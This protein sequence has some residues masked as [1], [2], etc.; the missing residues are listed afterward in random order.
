MFKRIW[1]ASLKEVL[2]LSY[3]TLAFAG[4]AFGSYYFIKNVTFQKPENC[5]VCHYMT[6]SYNKWA[7]STHSK[8]PCL[9]C[10]NYTPLDSV[11]SQVKFLA[12]TY[13]YNRRPLTN[14][15]DANCLQNGCHEK[16]LIESKVVCTKRQVQF[17]HKPHFM[18]LKRGIKLHCRSCHSDI[19]QG[20]HV[21]ASMKVCF[22]CHFMGA[23]K[24]GAFLGC[25]KCHSAPKG[26][27]SHKGRLF[28]HSDALNKGHNCAECHV[29]VESG[30]GIVPKEKCYFCHVER[31]DKYDDV[32]FVHRKHVTE[33]QIDCLFCHPIITHG[34]IRM[35]ED[36]VMGMTGKEDKK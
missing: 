25:G 35:S 6:P 17:D 16:R 34:K 11:S 13:A 18:E 3:F 10:H 29:E 9:K 8:V 32:D 2:Y 4:L 31:M 14:V 23:E 5:K 20:E 22:L 21:K 24:G 15:P 27:I 7:A 36:L 12:D 30:T 28:N 1:T 26:V 33:K 19:V